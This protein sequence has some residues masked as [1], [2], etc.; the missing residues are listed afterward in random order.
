MREKSRDSQR[1]PAAVIP[2]F[3]PMRVRTECVHSLSRSPCE[4]VQA[5]DRMRVG[6]FSLRGLRDPTFTQGSPLFESQLGA[7]SPS[8]HGTRLSDR[9]ENRRGF[10]RFVEELHDTGAAGPVSLPMVSFEGRRFTGRISV[11]RRPGTS[12]SSGVLE[13]VTESTRLSHEH[14]RFLTNAF[15]LMCVSGHDGYLKFVNPAFGRIFGLTREDLLGRPYIERIHPEDAARTLAEAIRLMNG[16]STIFFENRWRCADGSYKHIEWTASP[17]LTDGLIYA[18]G[19]DITERRHSEEVER[20]LLATRVEF[21]AARA[22][23]HRLLPGRAPQVAGFD[24]AGRAIPVEDAGGDYFDFVPMAGGRLAIV[25]GDVSGHGIAPSVVM[26]ETRT[27][28]WTTAPYC[29]DPVEVLVRVNEVLH[30]GIPEGFFVTLAMIEL[31]PVGR[32]IRVVNCGHPSVCV[33]DRAGEVKARLESTGL[34]LGCFPDCRVEASA[35]VALESGDIVVSMTDGILEASLPSGELFG[36]ERMLDAMRANHRKSAAGLADAA[37]VA[38]ADHASRVD[39]DIT[40]V[41][42]KV[43]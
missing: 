22:I 37:F 9:I 28:L 33:L 36:E 42:V 5:L 29:D 12:Y 6:V 25:V 31:D 35:P 4:I 39:D 13:D 34:P 19:R 2:I 40:I 18:A 16:E 15:D 41:V 7:D 17:A 14:D 26:A 27:C 21:D 43:L 1:S 10:E 30:A 20:A 3:R 32:S 8:L 23:Q 24:I 38:V 11:V